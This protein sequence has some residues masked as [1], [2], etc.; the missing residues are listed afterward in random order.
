MNHRY[1]VWYFL[2]LFM[3]CAVSLH[4]NGLMVITGMA[5]FFWSV[6]V[7]YYRRSTR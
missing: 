2:A 7:E 3:A 5:L 4:D 1:V 6:M